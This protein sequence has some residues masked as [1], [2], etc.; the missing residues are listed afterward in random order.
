MHKLIQFHKI[1]TNTTSKPNPNTD[2]NPTK[3]LI[4]VQIV[5]TQQDFAGFTIYNEFFAEVH[6]RVCGWGK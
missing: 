2:P 3:L 5:D 6:S 1:T 4:F